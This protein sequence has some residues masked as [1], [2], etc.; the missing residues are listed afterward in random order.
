[1]NNKFRKAIYVMVSALMLHG[2]FFGAPSSGAADGA[3][4]AARTPALAPAPPPAPAPLPRDG[5]VEVMEMGDPDAPGE[6]LV[7]DERAIKEVLTETSQLA[8]FPTEQKK[9]KKARRVAEGVLAYALELA[10]RTPPVTRQSDPQQIQKFVGLFNFRSEKTAFCAMGIAFAAAKVYC[11]LTP[12]RIPYTRRN[13]IRTF[14]TVL[15]LIDKYYFPPSPSCLF[16]MKEAKK[17]KSTQ[18][19]GWVAKGA[20][21]PRR[22]WLVLFDWKNRGDGIP[23]HIGII[24]AVGARGT[25][26]TVEFNTSVA[27]GSQR[28]G[29]A[30]AEKVRSTR[31]VLGFIRTY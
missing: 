6:T 29:G 27:N 8:A 19:G 7:Y 14:K 3:P 26:Y 22:G 11:D 12:E 15:P 25:L 4:P 24:K 9:Y 20:A 16:M 5:E 21:T 23:D 30:V 1:M 10:N 13:D 18:R 28:D 31:D 2:L 17:R